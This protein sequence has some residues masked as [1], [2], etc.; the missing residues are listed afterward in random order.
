MIYYT[1]KINFVNQH[2]DQTSVSQTKACEDVDYDTSLE[3][4]KL[5]VAQQSWAINDFILVTSFT[6]TTTI[7]T[8][9]E[10]NVIVSDPTGIEPIPDWDPEIPL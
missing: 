9:A 3:E 10:Y 2:G 8:L 1:Y 4:C 5:L 6:E 7:I